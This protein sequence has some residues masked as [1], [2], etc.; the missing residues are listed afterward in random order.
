MFSE[1]EVS[2]TLSVGGSERD[3]RPLL[4]LDASGDRRLRN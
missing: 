2:R 1:V 3:P 4:H